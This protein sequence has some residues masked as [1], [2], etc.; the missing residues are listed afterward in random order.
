M[1]SMS[2]YLKNKILDDNLQGVYVALI[3]NGNEIDKPSYERQEVSFRNA[4]E[5]Q[6]SND[7][8]VLFPIAEED[9]GDITGVAIFDSESGGNELFKSEPEIIKNIDKASQYK[10]PD[11]Y[12]V[13]R[14]R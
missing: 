3:S 11:S 13:I 2:N 8:D 5:G 6:T 10:I 1:S 9:W 4:D 12:L 7:I 14:L